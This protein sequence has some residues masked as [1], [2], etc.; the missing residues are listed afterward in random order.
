M[1]AVIDS[2][3]ELGALQALEAVFSLELLSDP[4]YFKNVGGTTTSGGGA[5]AGG[6][7]GGTMG[8][9]PMGS[10][11]ASPL[12]TP[13]GGGALG[14][15]TGGGFGTTAGSLAATPNT[16]GGTVGGTAVSTEDDANGA[17]NP[18]HEDTVRFGVGGLG[19]WA[20]DGG[21]IR[22]VL[23]RRPMHP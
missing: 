9:T 14:F 1:A 19:D 22:G 6:T 16:M 12:A 20:R 15:S 2:L 3:V 5:G 17:V 18:N 4:L 8:G 10:T 7:R 21:A 23:A 11:T 13:R